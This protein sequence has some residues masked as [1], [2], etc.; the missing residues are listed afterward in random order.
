[1]AERKEAVDA[2]GESLDP[3][4]SE[5]SFK[6]VAC[7][8]GRNRPVVIHNVASVAVLDERDALGTPE[9][10]AQLF[11]RKRRVRILAE[12]TA[13]RDGLDQWEP[14]DLERVW[15]GEVDDLGVVRDRCLDGRGR[16]APAHIS[17]IPPVAGVPPE[18]HAQLILRELVE[19]LRCQ[20]RRRRGCRAAWLLLCA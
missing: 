7:P 5:V 2:G 3:V 6:G 13:L 14:A 19:L 11:H 20:H 15:G 8:A 1:M 4:H 17:A 18:E 16:F 9:E 10:V 12:T